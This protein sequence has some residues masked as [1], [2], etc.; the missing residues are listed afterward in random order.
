LQN[1]EL[2]AS[3]SHAHRR[4][5]GRWVLDVVRVIAGFACY[6]VVALGIN[7]GCWAVAPF[8]RGRERVRLCQHILHWGAMLWSAYIQWSGVLRVDFPEAEKLRGLRGVVIAPNHPSLLD[9]TFFLARLPELTC[10]MKKAILRNPFLGVPSRLA[11]Y[12]SNDSGADFI[13]GGR[14]AL[15]IGENLLI[16][17]EGTRTVNPPVNEFKKGFALIAALADAPIQ[18][19]FIESPTLYLG[20]RW[21]LLRLPSMPVRFTLRLGRQFQPKPG[22]SAKAL[23]EELEAY[24][25]SQLEEAREGGVRIIQ[26]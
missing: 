16:F 10:L 19:V 21:P 17:P 3:V 25:R 2:S 14:D 5:L 6:G 9:A 4:S 24:F 20:K 15:R 1:I 7:A 11:G 13:R 8:R 12:L 22:Q 26:R 18:T 23:G